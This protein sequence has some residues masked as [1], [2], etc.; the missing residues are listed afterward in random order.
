MMNELIPITITLADRNYRI[1]INATD[2]E[3]LRATVK[4]LN[5][6]ILDFKIAFAGKDMQDYIT[7]VLLWFVTEDKKET[8]VGDAELSWTNE[9]I[10][11]IIKSISKG[12]EL[13]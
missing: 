10:Q 4:M 2:E 11:A 5:Q 6:K 12:M 3:K 1:R 7:M 9:K 8:S 13:L